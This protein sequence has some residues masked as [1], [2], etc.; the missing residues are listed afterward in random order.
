MGD[1]QFDDES[2]EG[3]TM[4]VE[5]ERDLAL[6]ARPARRWPTS[7]PRSSASPSA[8]TGTRPCPASRSQGAP[9]GD[10]V[11]D[12]AR[13]GEG[14]R[15]R[16]PL[17]G[18]RPVRCGSVRLRGPLLGRGDRRRPRPAHQALGAQRPRRRHVIDLV[19][20]LRLNLRTTRGW[21][22]PRATGRP[23]G[24]DPRHRRRRRPARGRRAVDKPLVPLGVGLVIG[25]ALGNVIDRLFRGEGRLDGAVVDFIDLQWWPMFNIADTASWSARSAAQSLRSPR[26]GEHPDRARRRAARPC[27]RPPRRRQPGRGGGAHRRRCGARRRRCRDIGQVRSRPAA[28]VTI[29][30]AAIAARAAAADAAVQFAVVHD[31]DDVIVV[32]KPAGLVVHPAPA[33][34]AGTLVN[35]LL[36]RFPDIAWLLSGTQPSRPTTSTGSMPGALGCSSWPRIPVWL[37]TPSLIAQFADP[38]RRAAVLR[39]W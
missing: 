6:S 20:T 15:D 13:R 30:T 7:T 1:V 31:D 18:E 25:G 36:A 5:R 4:V 26:S 19:W 21:R 33:T 12:R 37:P 24:P 10:P 3:D 27:R 11:G 23:L 14:R 29:D 17:S 22:S 32:D 39:L 35:G 9:G 2:G 34:P 8:P 38:P 28:S 16:P